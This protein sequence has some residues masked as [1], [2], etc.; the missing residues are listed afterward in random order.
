MTSGLASA[1]K[2]TVFTEHFML[3]E[4]LTS[5]LPHLGFRRYLPHPSL[6][7]WVQNYWIAQQDS[8]PNA[9]FTETLYADGGISLTFSFTQSLPSVELKT[10]QTTSKIIIKKS[11]D[12]IGVRF[13]PGGIFKLFAIDMIELSA[14]DNGAEI[15]GDELNTIQEKLAEVKGHNARLLIIENWLLE[16]TFQRS[17]NPSL[18][19]HLVPQLLS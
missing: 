17:P 16:K 7:L 9:G 18:L 2:Q 3:T 10:K 8:I 5:D 15:L 11:I 12:A 4:Q 6:Q 19:Q 13:H 1:D 14:I